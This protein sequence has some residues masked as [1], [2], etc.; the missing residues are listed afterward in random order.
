MTTEQLPETDPATS[1]PERF[2]PTDAVATLTASEHY[3]RYVWAAQLSKGKRVLDAGCGTGY[4]SQ[5]LRSA[6]AERIVAIDIAADAF[7]G[8][9]DSVEFAVADIRELP[10][11]DGEFD[12]VVCFEVIEHVERRDQVI[13]E[14]ARVLRAGGLLLVSSPNRDA[15]P[16][17]NPHHVYEYLPEE[18]EAEVGARFARSV[19]YRQDA[20]LASTIAVRNAGDPL[21][22]TRARELSVHQLQHARDEHEPYAI[23][24]ATDGQLP[25]M[26]ER[27]MLGNAF[28][29][30]WWHDRQA[31]LETEHARFETEQARLEAEHTRLEAEHARTRAFAA[32]EIAQSREQ[33]RQSARAL[34][35]IE[36]DRAKELERL[37]EAER[38]LIELRA[39]H[40][41]AHQTIQAM[42]RTRI[43]RL[44]SIY[45]RGRDRLLR[46][47]SG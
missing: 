7:R 6:G 46:R 31:R 19:L 13:A 17:G 47:R 27:V 3:L 4:G 11:A 38:E 10:Y 44:G 32:H 41:E 28:E 35:G 23:V 42:Q 9:K 43:W 36:A 2:D 14:F 45:W 26:S 33:A 40:H 12:I 8:D 1:S 39:A 16:A 22:P 34:I 21:D 5:I 29:L 30:Q 15:Y 25:E 37:R 24:V 20:W 18:L